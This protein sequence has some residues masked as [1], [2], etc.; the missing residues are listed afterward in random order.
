MFWHKSILK[1]NSKDSPSI[2]ESK[3]KNYYI[4]YILSKN[5]DII[6]IHFN[7]EPNN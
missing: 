1:S 3:P 4:N 6:T 5:L 2:K 7:I